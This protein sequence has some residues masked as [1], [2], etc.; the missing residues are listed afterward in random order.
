MRRK[1][2]EKQKEEEE[3]EE[4][5]AAAAVASGAARPEIWPAWVSDDQSYE[6][7]KVNSVRRHGHSREEA[8]PSHAGSARGGF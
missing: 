5:A 6:V 7:I 2:E 8:N 3:E 4:A 1:E